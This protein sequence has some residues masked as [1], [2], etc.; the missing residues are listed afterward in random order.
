MKADVLTDPQ[1]PQVQPGVRSKSVSSPSLFFLSAGFWDSKAGGC[2][3]QWGRRVHRVMVIGCR[4]TLETQRTLFFSKSRGDFV[5]L[6]G[7]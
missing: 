7:Q 1:I 2:V 6:W 5:R 3:G 4:L